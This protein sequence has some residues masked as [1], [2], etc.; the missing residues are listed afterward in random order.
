M[1]P[2][3]CILLT[4]EVSD[5]IKLATLLRANGVV[6]RELPCME[7]RWRLPSN[8]PERAEII[9]FASRRSV[10]G[11]FKA[12][13]M[14]TLCLSPSNTIF[15]VV[16]E[17]T[18]QSLRDQ[19]I[20]PEIIADTPTGFALAEAIHKLDGGDSKVLVV[21][22]DLVKGELYRALTQLGQPVC[23]VT[24]YENI[25]PPMG[26]KEPFPVAAVFVTAP[27]AAQRL[28]NH[29]PWL[30]SASFLPI[31]PTTE[32]ALRALGVEDFLEHTSTLSEQVKSLT[33]VWMSANSNTHNLEQLP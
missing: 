9:A 8:T 7:I 13:L 16:G 28:L 20:E 24:V 2:S 15:A 1:S 6:V 30:Q 31:G 25:K 32:S 27:S 33:R 19:G 18:A 21:H 29:L 14:E 12:G 11:F 10:I 5:N 17:A 26:T 22:G 3:P 23:D 4:R